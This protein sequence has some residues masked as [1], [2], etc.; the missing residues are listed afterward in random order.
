[1]Y[2]RFLH[3]SIDIEHE[4]I[5]KQFY[6]AIVLPQLQKMDGCRMASLIKSHTDKGVFISLTLWDE[7]SQAE[8]YEKSEAYKNLM[9]QIK[10]F[11]SE[12]SEWKMQLSEDFKLEYKPVYEAPERSNY[13]V[14]VKTNHRGSP[15]QQ[16]AGM[17]I[18]IVSVKIQPDKVKE[19]EKIYLSEIVPALENTKGCSVAY[20]IKS[21]KNNNE[22]LSIS[23]W[24]SKVFAEQYEASGKFDELTSK[25]KHTFSKFYLWKTELEQQTKGKV[26]TS[27][28][29][30]IDN[31]TTITGKSFN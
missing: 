5:V 24:E 22:F 27:E 8:K 13:V 19:F 2:M 3:L 25:L 1:M 28:D 7:K 23:L 9:E 21:L 16:P 31:Y 10:D 12:S 14:A 18:R 29:M 15:P 6:N 17:Y 20:L 4:E 30:K 26:E 11:L